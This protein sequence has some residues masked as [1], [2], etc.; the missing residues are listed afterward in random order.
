MAARALGRSTSS[1]SRRTAP[2][3][4]PAALP[5]SS[6]LYQ[7]PASSAPRSCAYSGICAWNALPTKN[8]VTPAERDHHHDPPLG[9]HLAQQ[10]EGIRE[11]EAGG[12]RRGLAAPA[13]PVYGTRSRK[14][15]NGR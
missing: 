6:T 4:A 2:R 12:A 15:V 11:P 1:V 7:P 8:D 3:T 5:A 13:W 14:S 9:A 10:A